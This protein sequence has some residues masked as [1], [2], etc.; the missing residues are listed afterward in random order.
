MHVWLNGHFVERDAASV[1]VFDAGFQ[2]AVGLFETMGV[3]NGRA[4][5]AT[6]H[7]ERLQRSAKELLLTERLHTRPLAQAVQQTIERNE[8][9]SARV[10][11]TL[12][13]GNLNMLQ[14][15]GRSAIDPTI[16]IVAQ[17]PTEYPESFFTRGVMALIA[18]DRL[19]PFDTMAGHKTLHYWPRIH[20]LQQAAARGAGEAIWFTVS[21]HLACGAV[22]NVLLVRDGSILTPWARGEEPEGAL[23]S[24][25]LPGIT[26]AAIL[27]L[28]SEMGLAI[29]RRML[30]IDDLLG[31]E[32]VFL[33]NSS[34]GI[35]PVVAVEREPI[36]DGMVGQVTAELREKWLDLVQSETTEA[37]PS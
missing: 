24:P 31:A 30:Q 20:S 33:T 17:P 7:L 12:T 21:N 10:R 8:M 36:G 29:E 5:R 14:S 27:A 3:S 18:D 1:P 4:F 26:R 19:N 25:V 2:H 6:A 34:W 9:E 28:A 16:L 11:L 35:L 23:R 32:E 13:G 37:A 22:S 15:T